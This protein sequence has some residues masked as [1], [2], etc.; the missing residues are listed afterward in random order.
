[1]DSAYFLVVVEHKKIFSEIF[2]LFDAFYHPVAAKSFVLEDVVFG[3]GT[4]VA[5]ALTAETIF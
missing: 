4:F 2:F 1:M 3:M 5:S